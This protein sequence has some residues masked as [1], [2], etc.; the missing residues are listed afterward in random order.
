LPN[1]QSVKNGKQKDYIMDYSIKDASP[2][3][4][5]SITFSGSNFSQGTITRSGEKIKVFKIFPEAHLPE[6]GTNWAACFDLKASLRIGDSITLYDEDNTKLE[7]NLAEED[8]YPG[9]ILLGPKERVLVPTG[10][11]FDLR[12][13]Q[14]V[15]IHPRSGLALKQ[16]IT[17]MNCEG[18]IDADYVQQTFVMIWNTSNCPIVIKDGDR[19]AQAEV[20][21]NPTQPTF[22]VLATAP[23]AKTNRIGGFGS[24]GI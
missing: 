22:Q 6:F 5:G 17:V 21:D 24:T 7:Y 3:T 4:V 20:V 16:G 2:L 11:I 23:A 15:R 14:S 12:S 19:I 8:Q 10:L 9:S 13:D 18:V 1:I